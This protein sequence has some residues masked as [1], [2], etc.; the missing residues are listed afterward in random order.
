[1]GTGRVTEP[2]TGAGSIDGDLRAAKAAQRTKSTER[3]RAL[4]AGAGPEAGTALAAIFPSALMPVPGTVVSGYWPIRDEI[5]P[6]PLL[7]MLHERGCLCA[8]PTVSDLGQPLVFRRWT[9]DTT[10]APGRFGVME[11][12][13]E[14]AVLD[15][16][17]LLV[18]LLAFDTTGFRLGYGAGFYD[19]S[20]KAL[21]GKG[22]VVAIGLAFAGQEVTA[23]PHDDDDEPLDWLV[24]EAG[25][26][27]FETVDAGADA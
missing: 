4:S 15:P 21:R 14:A 26:R 24:S 25:A 13:P 1:M 8:L 18:P 20:L 5:D 7:H 22:P 9:P 11:P 17:V 12:G 27:A 16:V 10:L 23:V 2:E 6:R 3:R 19:R